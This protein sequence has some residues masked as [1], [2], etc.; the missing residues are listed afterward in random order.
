VVAAAEE[1]GRLL[2]EGWRAERLTIE[3][4]GSID[5]VTDYDRKAQALLEARLE[6]FGF[7]H[8]VAEEQT[9]ALE[10]AWGEGWVWF[11]DPIDGTTNFAHGHPFFA[12]SVG[13]AFDGEPR[14][15]V[16][17]APGLGVT[18]VTAPDGVRRNGA[19]VTVS[20]R[21]ALAESVVAT[22]FPYD[23]ATDEENNLRETVTIAPRVRGIRR[24][25]AASLDLCLVAEGTYDGYWEQKL[26]PWDCCAGV[27]LVRAAGG[28]VTDYG[29]G[30]M[31]LRLGRLVA[32]NGRVHGELVEAIGAGRARGPL[33][34][35]A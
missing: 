4:K 18:W 12:V 35:R 7:G 5:L 16:V 19:L 10:G 32:T 6:A 17:C 23:R 11:V 21:G 20:Q 1:T 22:G 31:Q 2:L 13:L 28:R 3:H 26:K 24:C 8:V 30:P 33:V 29:G 25:G 34:S 27:A 14:W 15:G 9:D